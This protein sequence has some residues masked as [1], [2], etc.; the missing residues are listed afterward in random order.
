MQILGKILG[1]FGAILRFI[2]N[3]F[4]AMIFLLIVYFLFFAS[5]DNANMAKN[6]NL[7]QIDLTGAILSQNEILTQIEEAK[8][9]DFIKGVLFVVDS[10]GGALGLSVEISQSIKALSAKKPVLAYAIG[11]MASGSYLSSIWADKIYANA[12]SFI[13]S[14]GVIMQGFDI[15]EVMSKIGISEQIVSA[16]EFKQAGTFMRKWSEKERK[17]LQ[18]LVN[19]S[20]EFFVSEVASARNLDAKKAQIWANA[21]VFLASDAKKLGLI[22]EISSFYDAKAELI[23]MS[24][25]SQPIWKEKSKFEK[26]MDSFAKQSANFILNAVMLSVK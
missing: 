13:G 2:N 9:S 22:D 4:K 23:K 17:S 20:Y 5:I 8:N 15:S 18:N 6:A 14:I 26:V 3:H 1:F 10:P 11:T 24:G 21:R 12:G 25:V 16:G 7:Q 19:K